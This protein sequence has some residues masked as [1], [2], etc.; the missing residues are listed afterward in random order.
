MASEI[1]RN[2][3]I[4]LHGRFLTA[5]GRTD[6]VS[7]AMLKEMFIPKITREAQKALRD[8]HHFVKA[9]L[10]HY[11]IPFDE[12]AVIGNGTLLLKKALKEGKCDVVPP[13]ILK[14]QEDMHREWLD[15]TK[16][17]DLESSPEFVMDKFFLSGVGEDRRPD[18]GRT[19]SVV[20]VPLPRSS[21]YRARLVRE[22]AAQVEGLHFETGTGPRSQVIFMGWDVDAVKKA[23]K[24]QAAREKKQLEDEKK[25][26]RQL[27]KE[28]DADRAKMHKDYLQTLKK[29][30][31]TP[32]LVGSY[33]VDCKDVESEW[34]EDAEDMALDIGSTDE[35]GVFKACFDFGVLRGV[36]L[37]S[38]D[39]ALLEGY[40]DRADYDERHAFSEEEDDD[41]DD[42]EDSED[43]G[44]YQRPQPGSKRKAPATPQRGRGRPK[45]ATK[46]KSN[47]LKY[48]LKSR[49]CETGEGQIFPDPEDGTLKF[50]DGNLAAFTGEASLPCVG[51]AVSFTARKVSGDSSGWAEEWADY[52]DEVAENA[53][54]SRWH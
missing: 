29:K 16:I 45:K 10:Q 46:T 54:V 48:F 44:E 49:S 12:N 50:K 15:T 42:E 28:R 8:N 19:K 1:N 35:P 51:G 20:E 18:R 31:A 5:S 52:S 32:S 11:G 43:E 41:L 25:L 27:E 40:C 24:G 39:E 13:D 37:I 14:L 36:M 34:P 53:R 4:S 38:A 23:V 33:I 2:G 7:S 30:K 3:F 9:Q 17:E 21:E 47:P 22:A 6:R 26:A